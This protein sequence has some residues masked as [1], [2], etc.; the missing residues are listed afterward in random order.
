MG[1]IKIINR[2]KWPTEALEI[3]T[4]WICKREGVT[5]D[6]TVTFRHSTR[7][8]WLGRGWANACTVTV[9]RR[10]GKKVNGKFIWPYVIDGEVR[11]SGSDVPTICR[12]RVDLLVQLLAHEVCH[13]NLGH[14]RHFR[15]ARGRVDRRDMEDLCNRRGADTLEALREQW[16]NFVQQYRA[17]RSK[18]K[19]AKSPDTKR[20][21]KF[22]RTAMLLTQW[23]R[24]QKLAENK[25]KKYQRAMKRMETRA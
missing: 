5:W 17:A 6:Y 22:E 11:R 19:H 4:K 12:G 8:H 9:P 21:K 18:T 7:D 13:A 1:K 10:Y 2:S 20:E 15:N 23:Q 25:V 14:P 24:K 16:P 3:L